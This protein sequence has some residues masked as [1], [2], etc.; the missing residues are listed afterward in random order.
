MN[1]KS[2]KLFLLWLNGKTAEMFLPHGNDDT[3]NHGNGVE[4]YIKCI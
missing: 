2:Y 3:L 4:S 1:G